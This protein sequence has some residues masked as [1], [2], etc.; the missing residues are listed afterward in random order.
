MVKILYFLIENNSTGSNMQM[1]T[2][3]GM[4][5]LLHWMT[6]GY[7]PGG[8]TIQKTIIDSKY[9]RIVNTNGKSV[10]WGSKRN[11]QNYINEK[12]DIKPREIRRGDI[13]AVDR[14]WD[15]VKLYQHFAV[16]I[17][18]YQVIHYDTVSNSEVAIDHLF[19]SIHMATL[20]EFL[21][22]REKFYVL[23]FNQP[24]CEV[25]QF[26]AKKPSMESDC[27][28]DSVNMNDSEKSKLYELNNIYN[29]EHHLYSP[30]E[31]INRAKSKLGDR[32]YNVIL[33]NCEHFAIWCKT[34]LHKSEQ[35]HRLLFSIY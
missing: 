20:D 16:Y 27:Y 6:A 25:W 18:N 12:I 35:I 34:G 15:G 4:A 2:M 19:P 23:D 3:A 11:I 1:L 29:T 10:A 13:I 28:T 30:E 8:Y 33:N 22:G 5:D 26:K 9:Y 32:T 14:E 21:G 17:G 24:D 31:T 7:I